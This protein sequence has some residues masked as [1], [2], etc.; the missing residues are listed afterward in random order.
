MNKLS[1]KILMSLTAVLASTTAIA[2]TTIKYDNHGAG[3]ES[4]TV[5]IQDGKIRA[6]GTSG[7]NVFML[8]DT[9][10]NEMVIVNDDDRSYMVLDRE[11]IEKIVGMQKKMMAQLEQQLAALP[12]SQRAQMRKM[13]SGMTGGMTNTEAKPRRYE[14]T[15]ESKTI[16]GFECEML[17][18]YSGDKKVSE[19]CVA[20]P[21]DLDINAADFA[22]MESMRDFVMTLVEGMPMIGENMMEYGEPGQTEVPVSYTLYSSM[23]GT[24]GGEIVDVSDS[25]IDATLF[26]IPADY[27]RQK[28]PNMER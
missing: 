6:E 13:M 18:I 5:F 20:D 24:V 8:F 25:G 7:E 12:E 19:Q 11:E 23:A 1:S 9:R 15:G 17:M 28:L 22:T 16:G 2:D 4:A 27:K 14:R 10:D 21:S 26:T 3:S